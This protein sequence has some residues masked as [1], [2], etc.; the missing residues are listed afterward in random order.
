MRRWAMMAA[1][2][3]VT[4][5]ASTAAGASDSRNAPVV[6]PGQT[7]TF[8]DGASCESDSFDHH[9]TFFGTTDDN[10]PVGGSYVRTAETGAGNHLSMA[11]TTGPSAGAVFKG[12][13][14]R[15]SQQYLGNYS[16]NGPSYT[17][18]LS[19]TSGPGCPMATVAPESA[20]VTIGATESDIVTLTGA[21]GATP[22]GAINFSV[23]P[24]AT[25]P[26]DPNSATAVYLGFATLSGSGDTAT[27]TSPGFTPRTPGVY[28]FFADYT[29]S[30]QYVGIAE[31]STT[32]QCFSVALVHPLLTTAPLNPTIALGSS[33]TD[34]A[35]LTTVSGIDPAG[36]VSFSVCGPL[37]SATGCTSS[38][39]SPVG[40]PVAV[41][42]T[43]GVTAV[44]DSASFTPAA[45]GTYCFSAVYSGND[46]YASSSD[47]STDEC[48]TVGPATSNG[49]PIGLVALNKVSPHEILAGG[50]GQFVVAGDI[51]LNTDVS[52]QPWSGSAVDPANGV[53]WMWDDAIDA[54]TSSSLFVY[55]T[56]HSNNGT[57]NGQSLWPLDT[58]FQPNILGDGDPATPSPSY[59]AGDP[60]TQ[61]PGVQMSCSEHSGSVNIDYDNIDPTNTQID[62][63]LSG[64]AAPPNPLSA[65]TDIACPGSTLQTNPAMTVDSN[66]VEQLSPG[67]Y[68]TPV[69]ITGS[70]NFQDCPGRN[71]GIYRFDQGLWINP[72][73]SADTVTGSNVVI[74]TENPYPV[75]GNVPGS[76]VGGVFTASGTGNGAPCLPSTT[77]T[78]A[79]SGNGT[80]MAETS[81]NVCGGTD[82]TTNGVIGYGDSTFTAD[83]AETGTGADYS[84]IIGGVSGSSVSLTGPTSGAYGGTDRNPGLVLYQDPGTQADDGFDAEAG[85]AAAITIHGVVYNA[86]L[87]NYGADAPL[88]YWD[89]T[90]GAIP[91]FAGGTLQ[92]GFG[93]GW[94]HGPAQS[95]GS[96]SIIGTTVV[97]D[98]NTDGATTVTIIGQ[99]YSLPGTSSD[100]LT[101]TRHRSSERSSAKGTHRKKRRHL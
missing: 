85:D 66:G 44:A 82:P 36:T 37:P 24:G 10:A 95:A 97:D 29:G 6:R 55:G 78:S 86:S 33:D 100:A 60:A 32:D 40:L 54:K 62:D 92:A 88:D 41:T 8:G 49:P 70:A 51:F 69:E 20:S 94:S 23:C 84:T 13:F 18:R 3:L 67:E 26:C 56:I 53:S 72:Q 61:L 47:G 58:C 15:A 16:D 73:T 7:W 4:T 98:Y 12:R 25:D 46:D 96:V 30:T 90:G 50:T 22:G 28:C 68:T 17:A 38:A 9:G 83:P 42:P 101:G 19:P 80:P 89:G 57:D 43:S 34:T 2:L 76:V 14:R 31:M 87:S 77:M 74:G 64:P 5:T 27:A 48:F 79:A 39:G 21:G 99:P 93:T 75:A 11:W 65:S 45:T 63:P 59:Q 35:A 52:H 81:G 1:V 71:T 91:F